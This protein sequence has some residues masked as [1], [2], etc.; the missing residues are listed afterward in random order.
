MWRREGNEP[1]STGG[2]LKA[3]K[4]I[5]ENEKITSI[6]AQSN[7]LACVLFIFSFQSERFHIHNLPR[8]STSYGSIFVHSFQRDPAIRQQARHA[9]SAL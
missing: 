2:N 8:Q 1:I 9:N 4:K 5:S 6:M 3:A 7:Y